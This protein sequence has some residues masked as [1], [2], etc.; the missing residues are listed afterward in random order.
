MV[1]KE[2]QIVNEQNIGKLIKELNVTFVNLV[3]FTHPNLTDISKNTIRLAKNVP[4]SQKVGKTLINISIW[5]HVK[6]VTLL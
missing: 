1:S 4:L 6:Y 2:K 5:K 3:H